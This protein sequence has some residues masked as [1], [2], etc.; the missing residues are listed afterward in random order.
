MEILKKVLF[1]IDSSQQGIISVIL[2]GIFSFLAFVPI[3]TYLY[4]AQDISAKDRIMNRKDTGVVLLDQDGTPFFKFYQ[5][6][7]HDTVS[8][9]ET[10]KYLQ[11]AIITAEDK[12]F[13]EHPGFSIRGIIG[14]VLA[15]IRHRDFSYGGSTITQQLVKNSLLSTDRNFLRKYQEIVLAS[16]IERRYSKDEILEMYLNSVYFGEGAFGVED[17][18]EVYFDKK[19]YDLNLAESALLTGIL[20]APSQYS[21]LSGGLE[22]AKERQ[23]FVL[24]KMSE[25]GYIT[26]EQ[27]TQAQN[28]KLEFNPDAELFSFKAPHF[29]LYIKQQLIDKYGEEY[30]ARSGFVIRTSLD[31][32]KQEIAVKVVKDQVANLAKNNVSNGAAVVLNPKTGEIEAMVGSKD[33]NDEKWGKLNIVTT[34][35]Q[36]GS[37]FKPIIY[38]SALENQTITPSTILKDEPT[39]FPV[40]GDYNSYEYKNRLKF[41]KPKNYDGKF[42]GPVL[43]RKAL[44]NSLNVPS[45]SV[46]DKVGVQGGLEMAQKFGITDLKDF[47]QYG[48]SLVLGA[49]EVKLLELT[50]AYAVFASSGMR[51]EPTSILE[52]HDKFDQKIYQ[53]EPNPQRVISEEVAFIITSFLSDAISRKEVFGNTLDNKVN[54]AVKTGTTEYYKDALTLGYTNDEVIGVWVGNNYNQPMD[55]IA[56]SLGAA[57]IFKQLIERFSQK[58]AKF[59]PP[60]GI[61][62]KSICKNNGLLLR[63]STSSASVEYY[64]QGTEPNQYCTFSINPTQPSQN[65]FDDDKDND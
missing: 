24:Q 30:I 35:R 33:W 31:L 65:N 44:S 56:G 22:K 47:N 17:A 13:Y 14:A 2:L 20:P 51:N 39:E 32:K 37:S 59:T 42:R 45:V 53:Y 18:A 9:S 49:G 62:A 27:K 5:A 64:I 55:Q 23:I 7:V 6:K 11:Q 61:V 10:P 12:E 8:L 43:P 19:A 54:A 15:N 63:E 26:Q 58:S 1:K 4:F 52:I 57:P 3:L 46:M 16:E 38:A 21:P 50:N 40:D 29:A 41:Y 48:L 60:P 28:Q 34:P 36:P 25:E